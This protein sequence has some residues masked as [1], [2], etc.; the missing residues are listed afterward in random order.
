M[1][2][3]AEIRDSSAKQVQSRESPSLAVARNSP[4]SVVNAEIASGIYIPSSGQLAMLIAG[5]LLP[6][7]LSLTSSPLPGSEWSLYPKETTSR[8]WLFC[9][10]TI[11][12]A[13]FSCNVTQ[14]RVPSAEMVAYSGSRSWAALEFGKKTRTFS[15]SNVL[16]EK[17]EKSRVVTVGDAGPL[18]MLMMLTVPSGS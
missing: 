18:A 13:L 17:L 8:I 5:P 15:L 4:D 10:S 11:A 9:R 6:L 16:A 12:I 3:S 2:S 14:A 7:S 1:K